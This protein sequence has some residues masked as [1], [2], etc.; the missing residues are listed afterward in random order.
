[1]P[2]YSELG[3]CVTS[4]WWPYY[5]NKAAATSSFEVAHNNRL[6]YVSCCK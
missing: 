3:L 6:Y 2:S 5:Q 1:M 4:T